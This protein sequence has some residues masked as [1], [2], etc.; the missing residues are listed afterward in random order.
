MA[1]SH[2]CTLYISYNIIVV[3]MTHYNNS[4]V[5]ATCNYNAT[6]KKIKHGWLH[7]YVWCV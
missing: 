3:L 7:I 4:K 2:V 6:P 1:W 5:V